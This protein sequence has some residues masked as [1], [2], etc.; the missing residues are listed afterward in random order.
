MNWTMLTTSFL[1]GGLL[2]YMYFK[3]LWLTVNQISKAEHPSALIMVSF[4]IRSMVL[5]LCLVVL[6]WYMTFYAFASIISFI[7]VRQW[8]VIKHQPVKINNTIRKDNHA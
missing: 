6:F 5:L 8:M 7:I 1:I 3:G 4:M 2:S